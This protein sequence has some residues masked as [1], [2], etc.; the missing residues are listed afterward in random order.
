VKVLILHQHFKVPWKGGALRSYYLARALADRGI[1]VTVITTHNEP[2]HDEETIDGIR[3]CYLSIPYDNRFGFY[4]RSR[5][6]LLYALQAVKLTKIIGP[7]DL[8]YAISVP[9][10]TALAAIVL[11]ETY[12]LPYIFEVGD[13]WPDAPIQLGF[14]K[15]GFFKRALYRIEWQAYKHAEFVMALSPAIEAAIAQKMPGKRTELIPNM[16][17]T[18]FFKPAKKDPDFVELFHLEDKFVVSYIG[19][20]GFANG[21]EHILECARAAQKADLPV[22]F[23]LCGDGAMKES[24]EKGIKRLKLEN[25]RILPFKDRDGVNDLLSITD[26]VFI[27]YKPVPILETG[28][29]NKYFDGL[30]AGKLVI[31]NFGGWI[32]E[33]IEREHCGVFIDPKNPSGFVSS[34]RP[35]VEDAGLLKRYQRQARALAE[36]EYSRKILSERFFTIINRWS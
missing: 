12:N 21:L 30:A 9:L 3:V 15:N 16:A 26:A 19:A 23:F 1:H 35:F 28:S 17:D 20:L 22:Q 27:C 2:V 11:K 29:P 34:I 33:E 36:R 7:F 25:V 31:V 8:C 18:D 5:A 4:K 14:I 24:L 10:T 32:R 13:L 6:F